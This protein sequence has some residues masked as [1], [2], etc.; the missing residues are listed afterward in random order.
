MQDAIAM[1]REDHEKVEALFKEFEPAKDKRARKT[2][3]KT[4]CE[5]LIV[6]AQIE[7]EIF[8]PAVREAIGEDDLMD[9]AEVEHANANQLIAELGAMKPDEHHYDTKFI[10]LRELVKHHVEEEE[11]EIFPR[12]KKTPLDLGRLGFQMQV[13]KKELQEALG[14]ANK[15]RRHPREKMKTVQKSIQVKCPVRSVYNQWTQFEDFPRF[16]DGVREVKQLDDTHLWW[17][18]EI[19]GKDEIWNAEITEQ[20]PDKRIAWRSTSGAKNAGTVTFRG[21]SDKKTE[22]TVKFDYEPEGAVEKVGS[23]VGVLSRRVKG[24]LKRFKEFIEALG[25]ETGEWRG[26]VKPKR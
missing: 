17:R 19:G 2:I 1:L 22:V 5:E 18:A 26:T 12:V 6:H 11:G 23:A 14:I 4:A 16:M 24:D 25:S 15:S 10:V 7:E 21:L 13:R 3:V 9:E 8:Y 20:I